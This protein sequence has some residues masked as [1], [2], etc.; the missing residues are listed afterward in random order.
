MAR[1]MTFLWLIVSVSTVLWAA[2]PERSGVIRVVVEKLRNDRGQV[3]YGL[4]RNGEGFPDNFDKAFRTAWA[5]IE[6]DRSR[7]EFTDVPYGNYGIGVIHDE[8][9]N[10][11][12]DNLVDVLLAKEK[13]FAGMEGHGVSNNVKGVLVA[14]EKFADTVFALRSELRSVNITMLYSKF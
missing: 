5:S 12:L 13:E 10:G 14:S 8:N 1:M 9:N 4:F 6:G 11:Q 2:P 3:G 7:A